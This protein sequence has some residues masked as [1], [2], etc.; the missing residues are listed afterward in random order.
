[1]LN[2]RG[3]NVSFCWVPSHIGVIGNEKADT[4]AKNMA[5]IASRSITPLPCRDIFPYI[6][7]YIRETWQIAWE[8]LIDSNKKLL[9]ITK[10]AYP[11][12]Y[13]SMPRRW[14]TALCR[15]RIGHTRLT[16]G[17][18]MANGPQ[19]FCEDCLVPVTVK[20][21]LV[22]CPSLGE[23]RRRYLSDSVGDDRNYEISK[24]L[25]KDVTF[26]ASGVFN[27]IEEAG[28]LKEL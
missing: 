27:F 22:E 12:K 17:F 1:M 3:I 11:W 4:L 10:S 20:H 6:R 14:E 24:I 28:L 18:L 7:K 2:R 23:L 5:E 13:D 16:H 15:L 9:E 8:S 26:K 21:L 19:P 25:G